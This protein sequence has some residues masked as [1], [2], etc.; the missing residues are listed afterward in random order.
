MTSPSRITTFGQEYHD[1]LRLAIAAPVDN[2]VR[3]ACASSPAAGALRRKMYSFF[4]LLRETPDYSQQAEQADT[5]MLTLEAC[6][7]VLKKR[8]TTAESTAILAALAELEAQPAH[9]SV[10]PNAPSPELLS[11]LEA[12]RARQRNESQN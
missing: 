7:L 5:L 6:C 3:V 1:L 2:P 10:D 4:A 9:P 11:R 12:V 8:V